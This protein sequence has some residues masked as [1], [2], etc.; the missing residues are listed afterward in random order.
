M[1]SPLSRTSFAALVLFTVV[2]AACEAGPS[3][4]DQS[5]TDRPVAQAVSDSVVESTAPELPATVQAE[6]AEVAEAGG[7]SVAESSGDS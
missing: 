5:R 2:L 7:V 6:L 3:T 1:P 4:F